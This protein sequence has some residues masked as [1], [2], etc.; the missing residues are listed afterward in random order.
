MKTSSYP[1]RKI[2]TSALYGHLS[3]GAKAG[4][5]V[6]ASFLAFATIVGLIMFV[7]KKRRESK[8][9]CVSKMEEEDDMIPMLPKEEQYVD[10]AE[11]VTLE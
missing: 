6:A 5:G 9:K 3:K 7:L 8:D 11:G 1:S 10:S 2:T 4:L